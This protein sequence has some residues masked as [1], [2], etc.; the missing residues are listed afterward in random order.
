MKTLTTSIALA[1]VVTA[2][3]TSTLLGQGRGG[4]GMGDAWADT[5]K[6]RLSLTDS[7]YVKVKAIVVASRQN[8]EAQREQFAGDRE[9]MRGAFTDEMAKADK[10]IE[11]LLTDVQKKQY[12]AVKTER[13]QMR[14]RS[15]E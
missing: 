6:A 10:A 8:L 1:L 13:Q 14:R 5:L 12:A 7:Q 9:A 11:A 15:R 3:G 4:R 2:F